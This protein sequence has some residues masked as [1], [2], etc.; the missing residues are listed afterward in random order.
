MKD[1]RLYRVVTFLNRD[2]MDFLDGTVKDLYFNYGIKVPRAK[3]IEEIIEA[4]KDK[5][6]G[7]KDEF[8]KSLVG[9]LSPKHVDKTGED[10]EPRASRRQLN[11]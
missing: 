11:I 7:G 10:T 4:F 2:E 6:T 1:D 9:R 5:S 8:E 3:L